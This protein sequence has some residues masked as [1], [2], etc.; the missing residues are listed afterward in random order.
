MVGEADRMSGSAAQH[1]LFHDDA[2]PADGDGAPFG[3][4]HRAE[5]HATLGADDHVAAD[6]G[7][8][9]DVGGLLNVGSLALVFE[10]HRCPSP[11]R[12]E[13]GAWPTICSPTPRLRTAGGPLRA[14]FHSPPGSILRGRQPSGTQANLLTDLVTDVPAF[15]FASPSLARLASRLTAW[16]WAT[17]Q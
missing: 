17:S 10:Q 12:L 8:G 15:S 1:G 7:G 4:E 5:Q 14:H 6:G 9:G 16:V 11:P 13:I 3:D 2:M